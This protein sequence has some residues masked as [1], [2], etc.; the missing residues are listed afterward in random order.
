MK[1]KIVVMLLTFIVMVF[2]T[3]VIFEK[4]MNSKFNTML[5]NLQQQNGIVIKEIKDKSS[6]LT[7]D[8]F[9]EVTI[10]GSAIKQK[11][12]KYIKL[13]TEVKFKN[14]PVTNVIFHNVLT[15]LVLQNN[16][17]VKFLENNFVF[18]VITPDFK[19]YKYVVLNKSIKNNG[20]VI[21][22]NNFNG[23]YV[24]PKE[25]KNVDGNIQINNNKI[26]IDLNH[27]YTDN[28]FFKNKIE[29][30]SKLKKADV[31]LPDF[32]LVINNIESKNFQV[33]KKNKIDL[34]TSFLIDNIDSKL[35][36]LNNLNFSIKLLGIDKKAFEA[37]KEGD[38]NQTKEILDKG[39][40]GQISLN[41]KNI[42]FIKPLGFINADI[43]FTIKNGNNFQKLQNNNLDFLTLN[44]KINAS[45][46]IGSVIAISYPYLASMI[47]VVNNKAQIL[48]KINKGKIFINGKEIKSY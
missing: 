8:R 42:F 12:I 16:Q 21:S 28:L 45:P 27:I 29:Q 30:L 34:S 23:I 33:N 6:Y 25:F 19:H 44:A 39:F 4:L 24:Y 46:Q 48:I 14:L 2:A 10:P 41:I 5:L 47:N 43:N 1:N 3:P 35:F 32:K 38:E 18:N 9:F 15:K 40:K 13:L 17:E 7:T 37:L 31:E 22:W 20:I 26:K 36:K 11:E